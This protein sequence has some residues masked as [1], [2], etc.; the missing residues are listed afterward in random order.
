[1]K[2]GDTGKLNFDGHPLNGLPFELHKCTSDGMA[3]IKLVE[4]A[5]AKRKGYKVGDTFHVP[6]SAFLADGQ[7]VPST[8]AK[9]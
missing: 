2:P 3:I 1:M 4:K 7:P 9:P 8:Q 5:S 6:K